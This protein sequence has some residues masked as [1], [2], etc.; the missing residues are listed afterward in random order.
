MAEEFFVMLKEPEEIKRNILEGSQGIV[1]ILEIQKRIEGIRE[2][3]ERNVEVLKDNLFEIKKLLYHLETMLPEKEVPRQKI[4]IIKASGIA[5]IEKELK[6][7]D[8]KM[9]FL[10]KTQKKK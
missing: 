8:D 10:K 4:K 3:K 7:I 5:A 9:D 1:N 2:E 6:D